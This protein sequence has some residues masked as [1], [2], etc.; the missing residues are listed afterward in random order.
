MY[1]RFHLFL[2]EKMV[3]NKCRLI[4]NQKSQEFSKFN[5]VFWNAGGLNAPK[6]LQ[7]EHIIAIQNPDVF[8]SANLTSSTDTA[9]KYLIE[10]SILLLF[11]V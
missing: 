3:H 1:D 2:Y 4:A 10:T 6:L 7:I 8:A 5:V 9:L 11:P